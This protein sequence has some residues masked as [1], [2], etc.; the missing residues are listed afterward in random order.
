MT[1][2]AT[3]EAVVPVNGE[4][5]LPVTA[6]EKTLAVLSQKLVA[7]FPQDLERNPRL[8]IQ[9]AELC[10]AHGFNPI[11]V[12]PHII[13]YQG[14]PYVTYEGRWYK[15]LR[16]P[17][18]EGIVEDRPAEPHEYKLL[19]VDPETTV[20]WYFSI[21]L[22]GWARPYGTYGRASAKLEE[23]QPVVKQHE[24]EMARK[25]AIWRTLRDVIPLE[26][27]GLGEDEHLLEMVQTED[28]VYEVLQAK[29]NQ[30]Q[31]GVLHMLAK[32]AGFDESQYRAWLW[33]RCGVRSSK[34]L[35]EF[36]ATDLIKELSERAE[37]RQ[38][39]EEK[40]SQPGFEERMDDV[41]EVF[42]D[43]NGNGSDSRPSGE[44]VKREPA[45]AKAQAAVIDEEAKA[46][47]EL[48][49]KRWN[50]LQ[51]IN[52]QLAKM[53]RTAF[54]MKALGPSTPLEEI[55]ERVR[56]MEGHISKGLDLVAAAE[57]GNLKRA[58]GPV[59]EPLFDDSLEQAEL[60]EF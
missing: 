60:G 33:S 24:F 41:A 37:E 16:D 9:I 13:P 36:Q 30:G 56:E 17:R 54:P 45:R 40:R 26:I 10:V 5:S 4:S 18:F 50:E 51:G 20:V 2:V 38:S 31:I 12:P 6:Q 19:H 35:S 22:K 43:F 7:R 27:D 14:K 46:T 48:F 21:K 11:A 39:W 57:S 34:E 23:K 8:A 15:A 32:A 52:R 59:E 53:G 58:K 44:G 25:R 42:G 49:F 1:D 3:S 28:G 29:A 55:K 47:R